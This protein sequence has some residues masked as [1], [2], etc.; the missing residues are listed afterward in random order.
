MKFLSSLIFSMTL[1]AT[2]TMSQAVPY[3]RNGVYTNPETNKQLVLFV[4]GIDN[5]DTAAAN[6][7]QLLSMVLGINN[8]NRNIAYD[9]FHN[10]TEGFTSDVDE[11]RVQA[12]WSDTALKQAGLSHP[13]WSDIVGIMGGPI[14][15]PIVKN[16]TGNPMDRMSDETKTRYYQALGQLYSNSYE[17]YK[18]DDFTPEKRITITTKMLV[19]RIKKYLES[20]GFDTLVI[21]PHSQGNFYVEAAYATLLYENRQ[22]LLNRIRVVGVAPV[23]ATSPNKTYILDNSDRAI[24]AQRLNNKLLNINSFGLYRVIDPNASTIGDGPIPNDTLLMNHG[25]N[26]IYLNENFINYDTAHGLF[27]RKSYPY[28]IRS[29]V[30]NFLAE[31]KGIYNTEEKPAPIGKPDPGKVIPTESTLTPGEEPGTAS[32]FTL[33]NQNGE[34]CV[35]DNQTGLIWEQKT[36]DSGLH[37]KDNLYYYQ[38]INKNF[39]QQLNAQNYCGF[40]NWRL[41]TMDELKT[42][43]SPINHNPAVDSVFKNT[44]SSYYWAYSDNGYARGINFADGSSNVSPMQ[45]YVRAVRS[46]LAPAT[47]TQP[48][49]T[50]GTMCI[51]DSIIYADGSPTKTTITCN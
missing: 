40:N 5:D 13:L 34:E 14:V 23:S 25:F 42:I 44:Q 45:D 50:G 10:P 26:E 7:S 1:L 43:I 27:W 8:G 39:I 15:S 29:F 51:E 37:D 38:S 33:L 21:V 36:D 48:S 19:K 9:Y 16:T 12:N 49:K 47:I 24:M 11:L 30:D 18:G 17:K 22:D 3:S 32:R 20:D 31:L 6:S 46:D 35:K 4:N 28:I 2:S 41:P